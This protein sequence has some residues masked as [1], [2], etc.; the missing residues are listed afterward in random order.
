[1]KMN[2]Q[3]CAWHMAVFNISEVYVLLF[4][5]VFIAL[6]IRAVYHQTCVFRKNGITPFL[7]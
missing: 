3:P 6:A 2:K 7:E 5:P 1:M 4:K